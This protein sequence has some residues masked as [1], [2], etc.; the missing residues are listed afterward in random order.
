M[1]KLFF[2]EVHSAFYCVIYYSLKGFIIQVEDILFQE[3]PSPLIVVIK[4]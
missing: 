1:C 3:T 4:M 2:G